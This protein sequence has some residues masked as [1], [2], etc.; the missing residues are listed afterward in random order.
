MTMPCIAQGQPLLLGLL[1]AHITIDLK[2]VASIGGIVSCL[3]LVGACGGLHSYTSCQLP[4]FVASFCWM[5][6]G[7]GVSTYCGSV[8]VAEEIHMIFERPPVHTH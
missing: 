4:L 6:P 8:A 7:P 3:F 1:N 2:H 5:L